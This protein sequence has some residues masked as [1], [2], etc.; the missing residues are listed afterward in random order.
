MA[1]VSAREFA[2]ELLFD[3]RSDGRCYVHSP[4]IPGLHLAG[5]DLGALREDVEPAVKDLLH[6]N[7]GISVAA[8]RWVPSLDEVFERLSAPEHDPSK[9]TYVVT[10][11]PAA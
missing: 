9:A 10:I 11:A 1:Q 2:I 8:I 5:P 7:R 3:Q 4:S 6:L